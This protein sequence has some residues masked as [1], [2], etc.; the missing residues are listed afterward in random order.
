MNPESDQTVSIDEA[1]PKI[2]KS[3]L[4]RKTYWTITRVLTL[5]HDPLTRLLVRLPVG[6]RLLTVLWFA[7]SLVAYGLFSFGAPW[8]FVC[9]ALLV[10]VAIIFDLC[11]GEVARY[12]ALTMTPQRDL[13]TYVGGMYLDRIFHFLSSLLWPLAIALGLYRMLGYVEVFV[14]AIGLVLFHGFRRCEPWFKLYLIQRFK[15]KVSELI[16]D[17][18]LELAARQPEPSES[19]LARVGAK[20]SLWVHNG[21]RFNFLLLLGG[22]ADCIFQL[23][24]G[25]TKCL[26]LYGLFTAAGVASL[27]LLFT[28]IIN[29]VNRNALLYEIY[30]I[31]RRESS[32]SGD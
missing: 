16:K 26:A 25:P 6:A 11:D 29:V 7:I 8:A 23:T 10:Y 27:F 30:D 2:R 12:R 18:K 21:K 17:G 31:C 15:P 19:I 28:A 24:M 9:G 32:E 3:R 22:I 20:I 4:Q 14:A 13:E 5:F 1:I